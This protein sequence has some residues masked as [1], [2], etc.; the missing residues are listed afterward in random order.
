MKGR[1]NCSLCGSKRTRP[2]N[3]TAKNNNKAKHG[4]KVGRGSPHTK[5]RRNVTFSSA[6]KT[7]KTYTPY[8]EDEKKDL[9]LTSEEEKTSKKRAYQERED[10]PKGTVYDKIMCP[11]RMKR[12]FNSRERTCV[13]DK[14]MN[15][16]TSLP[17]LSAQAANERDYALSSRGRRRLASKANEKW[18]I[19]P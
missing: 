2:L 16:P 6:N 14:E 15:S 7:V 5:S 13:S 9:Y 19:E 17:A 11:Y 10:C 8:T 3:R 4:I 1:K 18:G 12:C